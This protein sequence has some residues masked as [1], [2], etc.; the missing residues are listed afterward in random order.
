MRKNN[1]LERDDD[2]T[3]SHPA[4]E[5]Q[6]QPQGCLIFVQKRLG[7]TARRDVFIF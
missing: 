2:S 5:S 1:R 6:A 3:D 4:L 7:G